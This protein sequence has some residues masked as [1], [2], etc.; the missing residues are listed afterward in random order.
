MK[1]TN[2]LALVLIA[3]FLLI[4]AA[5]GDSDGGASDA[6][7]VVDDGAGGEGTA[8]CLAGAPDCQDTGAQDPGP[9]GPPP[10]EDFGDGAFPVEAEP[11]I[12]EPGGAV[13]FSNPQPWEEVREDG[14]GRETTQWVTFTAP[15]A[16][17]TIV[18]RVE[19]TET[20]FTVEIA[21]F[22]G[23]ELG[24]E[25]VACPA[26]AEYRAVPISLATPIAG[27][28]LIDPAKVDEQPVP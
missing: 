15:P 8:T 28:Q 7:V 20:V 18:D 23:P 5:C 16:P 24:S 17:C 21:L 10:D 12:S 9:P 22:T 27:R 11:T 4:T 2:R 25:G 3:L 14:D 1:S 19:V 26:I 6:D 13:A